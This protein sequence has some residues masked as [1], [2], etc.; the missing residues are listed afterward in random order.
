MPERAQDTEPQLLASNTE[1]CTRNTD[2]EVQNGRS[3]QRCV[4]VHLKP[5]RIMA[6]LGMAGQVCVQLVCVRPLLFLGGRP[7]SIT[8]GVRGVCPPAPQPA[9]NGSCTV[10]TTLCTSRLRHHSYS[11][12][13]PSD[14]SSPD[15]SPDATLVRPSED[16]T[17]VGSHLP[18]L[19]Q[20]M[21]RLL[22]HVP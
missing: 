3:L 17:Q 18:L 12:S 16:Q 13:S 2:G 19:S 21:S 20:H 1:T 9:G 11:V 8:W 15:T 6:E 14:V 4:I 22:Y 5:W 7:H 10:T